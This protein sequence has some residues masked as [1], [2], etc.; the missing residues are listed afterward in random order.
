MNKYKFIIKFIANK[1]ENGKYK[2]NLLFPFAGVIIGCMTVAL[3]LSIMEGMEY[4]IFTKLENMSFPGKLTNIKMFW[5][6][7]DN[8]LQCKKLRK[9]LNAFL[10]WR[11]LRLKGIYHAAQGWVYFAGRLLLS[12]AAMALF[13]IWFTPDLTLWLTLS[14]VDRVRQLLVICLLGALVYF[15]SM[16]AMGMR[17]RDFRR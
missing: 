13:L 3:T 7:G 5:C 9:L 1:N 6:F 10:L 11:G 14:N 15:L 12:I 2:W 4:A 17:P 16:V 8:A